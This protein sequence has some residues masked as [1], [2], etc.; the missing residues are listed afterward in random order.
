VRCAAG[1]H[2]PPPP[3]GDGGAFPEVHALQHPLGMGVGVL[4]PGGI[5]PSLCVDYSQLQARLLTLYA[6]MRSSYQSP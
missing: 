5:A 2:Q 3:V 4:G 1:P 6:R